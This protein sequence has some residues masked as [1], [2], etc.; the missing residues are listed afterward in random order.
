MSQWRN[1]TVYLDECTDGH[2]IRLLLWNKCVE[3]NPDERLNSYLMVLVHMLLKTEPMQSDVLY[4]IYNLKLHCCCVSWLWTL[5][6]SC[7]S[8]AHEACR[9]QINANIYNR[10]MNMRWNALKHPIALLFAHCEFHVAMYRSFD[11]LFGKG[12]SFDW[13]NKLM[14]IVCW[15]VFLSPRWLC[16]VANTR[17]N[18]FFL[19]LFRFE[20]GAENQYALHALSCRPLELSQ[21][22]CV[23]ASFCI[24]GAWANVF[25]IIIIYSST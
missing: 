3:Q 19:F 8:S 10:Y 4:S 18:D 6:I 25:I 24:I 17:L 22:A 20:N 12:I 9:H 16:A 13:M 23:K 21:L 15:R 1:Q 7:Y 14:E 5:Q 11:R 2:S